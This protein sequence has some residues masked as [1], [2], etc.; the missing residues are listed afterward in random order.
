MT[1]SVKLLAAAAA[2]ACGLAGP[3]VAQTVTG[4]LTFPGLSANYFDRA[5]GGVPPGYGNSG[6]PTVTINGNVE[7]GYE[8]S[9]NLYIANFTPTRVGIANVTR[10][11]GPQFTMTFSTTTAGL[12]DNAVLISSF[13][14]ASLS[15]SNNVLT[16]RAGATSTPGDRQAVISFAPAAGAVPEPATWAMMLFGFGAAGAGVR[17]Q[18]RRSE[19]K[20]TARI[21]LIEAG[22]IA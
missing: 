18:L 6:G 10:D 3:A 7:F 14:G 11:G 5:N 21:K 22:E 13:E 2:L 12:F 9:S 16:F 1:L 4:T 8:D 17:R 19:A 15:V 20:F